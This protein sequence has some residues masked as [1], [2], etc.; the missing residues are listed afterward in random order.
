MDAVIAAIRDVFADEN[1]PLGTKDI[2]YGDFRV[3]KRDALG[4]F[5]MAQTATLFIGTMVA[6]KL[7]DEFVET[8]LIPRLKERFNDAKDAI[9]ELIKR[10]RND[11]P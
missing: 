1:M 10:M 3:E 11:A 4:A 6:T 5:E 9:E 7:T 2:A 8:I